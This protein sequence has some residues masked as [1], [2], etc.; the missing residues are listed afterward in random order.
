[1]IAPPQFV[2][3]KEY[4]HLN[5]KRVEKAIGRVKIKEDS[6]SVC[7]VCML[8]SFYTIKIR[9]SNPQIVILHLKPVRIET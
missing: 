6:T 8:K 9:A 7:F 3:L 4:L 1:V 5:K 2:L